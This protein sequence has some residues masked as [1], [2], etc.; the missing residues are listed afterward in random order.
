MLC[1]LASALL[2]LLHG[3]ASLYIPSSSVV[4]TDA[5][6][7]ASTSYTWS[8]ELATSDSDATVPTLPVNTALELGFPS[9]STILTNEVD[10]TLSVPNQ[11]VAT[12]KCVTLSSS[13]QC[14]L[15]V[16]VNWSPMVFTI[17]TIRNSKASV[18]TLV[19]ELVTKIVLPSGVTTTDEAT[20][21][22]NIIPGALTNARFQPSAL[23]VDFPTRYLVSF[24]PRFVLEA[25][26]AIVITFPSQTVRE[27]DE[28]DVVVFRAAGECTFR[29][30]EVDASTPL[31]E[32][33]I[34]TTPQFVCS[35]TAGTGT[36]DSVVRCIVQSAIDSGS[37]PIYVIVTNLKNPSYAIDSSV[38]RVVRTETRSSGS[39]AYVTRDES[40]TGVLTKQIFPACQPGQFFLNGRFDGTCSACDVGK[41]TG[42]INKLACDNCQSGTITTVTG[43]SVCT[44]CAV[45]KFSAS[46]TVCDD[47][48]A[49]SYQSETGKSACLKCTAGSISNTTAAHECA[50]CPQDSYSGADGSTACTSCPTG[51]ATAQTGSSSCGLCAAGYH[52]FSAGNCQP[53]PVGLITAARNSGDCSPCAVG[54]YNGLTTQTVCRDCNS[55]RYANIT[56]R[57]VCSSC[58]AG[59]FNAA[60]GQTQCTP[61]AAGTHADLALEATRCIDC[62]DGQF[63]VAGSIVCTDC[64]AG[65]YSGGIVSRAVC[66]S[67]ARGTYSAAD[68]SS[69]CASCIPGTFAGVEGSSACSQCGLG[70][71]AEGSS[72]ST[73]ADCA[74][75]TTA[76][77]LGQAVCQPCPDDLQ[78]P[79]PGS[80]QCVYI[81]P[82]CTRGTYTVTVGDTDR[83][84]PC[85]IG[86]YNDEY[87]KSSCKPC[88][89]GTYTDVTS[90]SF[91]DAC[92]IGRHG[93]RTGAT[94]CT[95]CQLGRYT[96]TTGHT[97]CQL[98]AIG[99]TTLATGQT[100]CDQCLPG[101][102]A[103]FEGLSACESCVRG[104][105]NAALASSACATCPGLTV[106]DVMGA[107]DVTACGVIVCPPLTSSGNDIAVVV[108]EGVYGANRVGSVATYSCPAGFD[109]LGASTR[110][111]IG[112]DSTTGMWTGSQPTCAS[113]NVGS[114]TPTGMI[115]LVQPTPT[116]YATNSQ[117]FPVAPVIAIVDR[118]NNPITDR[119]VDEIEVTIT[120][121]IPT[122]SLTDS[123]LAGV[124]RMLGLGRRKPSRGLIILDNLALL[125]TGELQLIAAASGLSQTASTRFTV[126]AGPAARLAFN[127]LPLRAVN[128]APITTAVTVSVTDRWGNL[129]RTTTTGRAPRV[130]L[131]LADSTLLFNGLQGQTISVDA[132][133]GVATFSGLT[134]TANDLTSGSTTTAALIASGSDVLSATSADITIFGSS[135][136]SIVEQQRDG[137]RPAVFFAAFNTQTEESRSIAAFTTYY[138]QQLILDVCAALGLSTNCCRRV[139]L[140]GFAAGTSALR[141]QTAAVAAGP[142]A[143]LAGA[144]DAAAGNDTGLPAP[145][146]VSVS[147]AAVLATYAASPYL[148]RLAAAAGVSLAAAARA[149]PTTYSDGSEGAASSS[150]RSNGDDAVLVAAANALPL[151]AGKF[152][153]A[154]I[155]TAAAA[156]AAARF[157]ASPLSAPQMSVA[158]SSTDLPTQYSAQ[159]QINPP[160]RTV[161][162][163]TLAD[164]LSPREL[165]LALQ[166]QAQDQYSRLRVGSVAS[167]LNPSSFALDVSGADVVPLDDSITA[168]EPDTST[169]LTQQ[170]AFKIGIAIGA[171]V[172][173]AII[174]GIIAY[175]CMR[176]NRKE[177]E[178]TPLPAQNR[179]KHPVEVTTDMFSSVPQINPNGSSSSSSRSNG[180]RNGANAVTNRGFGTGGGAGGAAGGPGGRRRARRSQPMNI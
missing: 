43:T 66:T 73:C 9:T 21:F 110:T 105:Y 149:D 29:S 88:P 163:V 118:N 70:K 147:E 8:I 109:V 14:A 39:T 99:H 111:C 101:T 85:A 25:D 55:G 33:T 164:E 169:P 116:I 44:P 87:A 18:S 80:S 78:A 180:P 11:P 134:I 23:I 49:G 145:A 160:L 155:A 2:A 173:G 64:P 84:E 63:A 137:A 148:R 167:M 28:A 117:Q 153:S 74:V 121:V 91:C 100:L 15:P 144:N 83:C 177:V 150:S 106:T 112:L 158:Q 172:L 3:A 140:V 24:V 96:P 34:P 113:R 132:V 151:S 115:W 75:N 69:T 54:K 22:E 125:N 123:R 139:Q 171:A 4:P 146:S 178:L 72:S 119:S 126:A 168:E 135:S 136:N 27:N 94:V 13:L 35:F 133:N 98:C 124:N 46:T 5:R 48:Q 104:K 76:S 143:T 79:D 128:G 60:N 90:R 38:T 157:R 127:A 51:Y 20:S 152:G 107:A 108:S 50:T 58:E 16:A 36:T 52:V 41:Y 141:S 176:K 93:P 142:F 103:P 31:C 26:E 1:L 77:T 156:A 120:A 129:V 138:K 59:R 95:A 166:A 37:N 10:F 45:G 82:G 56:G 131:A 19:V 61:C 179:H 174:L 161:A 47:C 86:T 122:A 162:P 159:V 170:D 89:L 154:A 165:G 57:S 65:T 102:I 175:R 62:D 12:T 7:Y 81:P 68:K 67:C 71:F 40:L 17:A 6:T 92:Q 114:T 130:T 53:C 42:V 32:S 30:W 97:A